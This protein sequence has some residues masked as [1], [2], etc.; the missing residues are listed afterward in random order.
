[1]AELN[2]KVKAQIEELLK[3]EDKERVELA[4]RFLQTLSE[5]GISS[6]PEFYKLLAKKGVELLKNYPPCHATYL[7]M[8]ILSW[9][10][11]AIRSDPCIYFDADTGSCEKGFPIGHCDKCD[12]YEYERYEVGANFQCH[13]CPF[14]CPLKRG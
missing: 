14:Q 10:G 11:P 5:A 7:A 13:N 9:T 4:T 6:P 12:L 2:P 8:E 1:M 3:A